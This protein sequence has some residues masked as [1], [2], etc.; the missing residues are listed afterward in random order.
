MSKVISVLP[1]ESFNTIRQNKSGET[2]AMVSKNIK[3]GYLYLVLPPDT[4][5]NNFEK[6][7]GK[8][9]VY[10]K[11]NKNESL[12]TVC[13]DNTAGIHVLSSRKDD[14]KCIIS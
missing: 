6:F 11:N 14:N 12:D 7:G 13:I 4:S 1:I 9:I 10:L 5:L 8:L 2:A 3:D